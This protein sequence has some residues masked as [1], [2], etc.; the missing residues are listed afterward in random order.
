MMKK[1]KLYVVFLAVLPAFAGLDMPKDVQSMQQIDALRKQASMK[2][3]ALIFLKVNPE[4]TQDHVEEAVD[5]YVRRFKQYGPVILVPMHNEDERL[6]KNAEK[7][8]DQFSGIYPQLVVLDPDDDTVIVKVP[9][10]P[11]DDRKKEM[12]EYR[13]TVFNYLKEKKSKPRVAPVPR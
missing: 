9:Y 5:D 8:F 12:R 1:W 3:E 10:L 11:Q 13:K 6:P 4:N 2:R 7:A